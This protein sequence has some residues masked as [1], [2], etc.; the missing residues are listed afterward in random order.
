MYYSRDVCEQDGLRCFLCH[1]GVYHRVCCTRI[2]QKASQFLSH[3]HRALVR[4]LEL[5]TLRPREP[6]GLFIHHRVSSISTTGGAPVF[7]WLFSSLCLS[8]G[9]SFFPMPLLLTVTALFILPKCWLTSLCVTH[10]L[11]V[12]C[13]CQNSSGIPFYIFS[14]VVLC[15]W[16]FWKHLLM[17]RVH[18]KYTIEFLQC[19]HI[20]HCSI[21]RGLGMFCRPYKSFSKIQRGLHLFLARFFVFY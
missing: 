16:T 7:L 19:P 17:E 20:Y 21:F 12:Q 15:R 5:G 11:G 4:N 1:L 3:S 10:L 6:L 8:P 18:S 2:Y 9:C 13:W 14:P